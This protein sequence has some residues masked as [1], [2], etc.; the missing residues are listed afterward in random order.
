MNQRN[1]GQYRTTSE[2]G[3]W[4][5]CCHAGRTHVFFACLRPLHMPARWSV[6]R[7]T[8]VSDVSWAN[9]GTIH[10][11][12]LSVRW[13]IGGTWLLRYSWTD[14]GCKDLLETSTIVGFILLT[15]LRLLPPPPSPRSCPGTCAGGSL[16]LMLAPLLSTTRALVIGQ[17][18]SM[19]ERKR[20]KEL[21]W[22]RKEGK[23]RGWDTQRKQKKN[24][25][26]ATDT[27][28]EKI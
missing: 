25:H 26:S 20:E 9:F 14:T 23:V 16:V 3:C 11:K 1:T 8:P 27:A 4:L 13:T 6:P 10:N 24:N 19:R 28:K 18:F 12:P 22:T 21:C 17:G 5:S 7:R 15:H 2:I